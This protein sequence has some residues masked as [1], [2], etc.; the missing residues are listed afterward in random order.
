MQKDILKIQ[1]DDVKGELRFNFTSGMGQ[2]VATALMA[3]M[4]GNP[5]FRQACLAAVVNAIAA[6]DDP[7]A[8]KEALVKNIDLA[9]G[10]A[11]IEG[12]GTGDLPDTDRR[13]L[14]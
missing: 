2:Q 12:Q 4:A 14:S 8:W 6:A 10:V 5:E 7:K 1:F 3:A 11:K 13:R 9:A